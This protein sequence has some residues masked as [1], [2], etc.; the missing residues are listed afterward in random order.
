MNRFSAHIRKLGDPFPDILSI[1]IEF[2]TLQMR[3]EDP[4]VRLRIHA[5]TGAE[6][7][8]PIVG[9]KIPVDEMFH[10]IPLAAAPVDK[11]IFG[12]EGGNAHPGAIMHVAHVVEL[13][14]CGVD[15]WEAG[16]PCTPFSE[17]FFVVFPFDVSVFGFKGFIHADIGPIDK[18]MF[19]KI[20]PCNFRYPAFDT[21]IAAVEGVG[22]VGVSCSCDGRPGAECAGREMYAEHGRG[23]CGGKIPGVLVFSSF[24][25][26]EF[27]ESFMRFMFAWWPHAPE[28]FLHLR[29]GSRGVIKW[30]GWSIRCI[31]PMVSCVG[32]LHTS[33][34][35]APSDLRSPIVESISFS[36]RF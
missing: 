1:G 34:S 16:L 35:S 10:E 28:P 8:S 32:C 30:H 27:V 18:D 14:H 33:T 24:F 9:C 26:Q 7:P 36:P 12:E 19:V 13:A 25:F 4:E 23:V 15:E 6:S 11:Q 17:E 22:D 3:V 2:L 29:R 5:C 21:G 31:F 20:S